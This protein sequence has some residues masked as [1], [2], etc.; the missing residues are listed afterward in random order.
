VINGEKE[1]GV[2]T[3]KLQHEI[4][5]G[6][7]LLQESFPIGET[8]TAGVVHDTMMHIG[9]ALLL[10]T[11]KGLADNTLKEMPQLLSTNGVLKHAPKIFTETCE[12]NTAQSTGEVYNLIRGLSPYPA[13]FTFLKGKK[14]KIYRAEKTNLTAGSAPGELDTDGKT[15]LHLACSDGWIS[16][17]EIQLEGKK[18]MLIEDFL[19]GY[20]F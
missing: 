20:R 8:D 7:I 3:F 14:L 11:V 15:Y 18:R 9:A 17:L 19:R 2:T 4:D 1:T 12:I 5:T 6:D 10:K 13:A 16:L